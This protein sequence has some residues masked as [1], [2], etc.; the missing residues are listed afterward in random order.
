[1]RELLAD[2]VWSD[3]ERLSGAPCFNVT[4]VPVQNLLDYL[5]G[6]S[7]LDAFFTDF[8]YVKEHQVQ[9]FLSLAFPEKNN[10]PRTE[11]DKHG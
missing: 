10:W 8:P 5:E 1:M 9:L 4:R 3:P 2:V 6:G 7:S 11:K